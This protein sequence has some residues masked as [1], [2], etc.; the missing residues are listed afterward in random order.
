MREMGKSTIRRFQCVKCPCHRIH[1]GAEPAKAGGVFLRFGDRYCTGGR[2]ARRFRPGDPKVYPPSWCPRKKDPVEYRIY[3][4]KD[5]SAWFLHYCLQTR[6]IDE[7]PSGFAYALRAE[8]YVDCSAS[9]FLSETERRTPSDV[10]GVPVCCGEVIEIDDGLKPYFFQ[11]SE[12]GVS[13][14]PFFNAETARQ[15]QYHAD[16][17]V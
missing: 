3:A 5:S 13:V 1:T 2:K 9:G 7:A 8:G 14:V 15:N 6:G 11:A 12:N 4:F 16:G 10:L 17:S